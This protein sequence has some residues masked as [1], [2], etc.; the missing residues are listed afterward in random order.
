MSANFIPRNIS[1]RWRPARSAWWWDF[2][3]TSSRRKSAPP[4]AKARIA[5]GYVDSEGG[6][7]IVVRQFRHS[8]G[9]AGSRPRP[10]P[11]SIICSSPTWRRKIPISFPTPTAIWTSQKFIDQVDPR[12]SHDLSR[13]RNYGEALHHHRARPEDTAADQPAVDADQDRTLKAKSKYPSGTIFDGSTLPVRSAGSGLRRR[14]RI[15]VARPA[16]SPAIG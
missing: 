2:P 6:R 3:A 5:V 9:R 12:R 11:S 16:A 7:A 8:Q 14:R 13:R 4:E 1:M 10:T 15:A